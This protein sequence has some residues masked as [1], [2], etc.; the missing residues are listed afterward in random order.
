MKEQREALEGT[1]V[2]I[3][4]EGPERSTAERSEAG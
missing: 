2:A 4:E 3:L 1:G